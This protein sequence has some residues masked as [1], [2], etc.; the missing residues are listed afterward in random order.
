M[1]DDERRQEPDDV[2]V[3]ATDQYE[4][5]LAVALRRDLAGRFRSRLASPGLDELNGQH[6]AAPADL[7]DDGVSSRQGAK[8]PHHRSLD[9]LR[10]AHQLLALDGFQSTERRGAGDW[11]AGIGAAEA[12]RRNRV[13]E[14]EHGP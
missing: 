3:G 11:V 4:D 1:A 14:L 7:A 12:P 13:H 9:L 5:T 10:L 8:P 6:G 2:A